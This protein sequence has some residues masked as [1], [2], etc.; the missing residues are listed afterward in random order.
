MPRGIIQTFLPRLEKLNQTRIVIVLKLR[1]ILLYEIHACLYVLYLK[2]IFQNHKTY[3]F[4][5]AGAKF[6]SQDF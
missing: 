5:S 1:T 4:Q 6:Q 3:N 2:S